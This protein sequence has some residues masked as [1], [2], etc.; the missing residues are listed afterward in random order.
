MGT[1]RGKRIKRPTCAGC[2]FRQRWGAPIA[3]VTEFD[4]QRSDGWEVLYG[5][6]TGSDAL[7]EAALVEVERRALGESQFVR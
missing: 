3:S 4:L 7:P 6:R 2:W 5:L 1:E